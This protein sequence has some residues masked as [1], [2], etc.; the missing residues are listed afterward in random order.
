MS[1]CKLID[2][3]KRTQEIWNGFCRFFLG[4]ARRE[5]GMSQTGVAFPPRLHVFLDKVDVG[6]W[7]C[8]RFDAPQFEGVQR[9]FGLKKT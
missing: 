2:I 9:E 6:T 7:S 1:G 3:S 8:T 4:F 5:I